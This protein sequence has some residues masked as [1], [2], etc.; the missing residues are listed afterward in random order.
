MRLVLQLL[1]CTFLFFW[2]G[3]WKTQEPEIEYVEAG[4]DLEEEDDIE[5]FG[6]FAMDHIHTD[7]DNGIVSYFFFL[8]IMPIS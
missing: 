5:D 8:V 3:S 1:T 7:D 2:G 6:G 4:D